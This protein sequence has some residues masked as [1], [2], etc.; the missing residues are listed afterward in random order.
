MATGESWWLFCWTRF[1]GGL[2]AG[3]GNRAVLEWTAE[4]GCPHI[5]SFFGS[6]YS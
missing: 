6:T 2:T 4:G 1:E 5:H 3:K